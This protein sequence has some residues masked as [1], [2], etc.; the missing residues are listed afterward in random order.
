MIWFLDIPIPYVAHLGNHCDLY[1]KQFVTVKELTQK[2][3][4]LDEEDDNFEE[5]SNKKNNG[6]ANEEEI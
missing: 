1:L 2:G 3:I 6:N 4:S 5:F